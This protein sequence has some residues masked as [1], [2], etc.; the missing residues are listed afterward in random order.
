[1]K[2]ISEHIEQTQVIENID[3]ASASQWLLRQRPYKQSHVVS[4]SNVNNT[5]EGYKIKSALSY[6]TFL[7]LLQSNN[8]ELGHL[9]LFWYVL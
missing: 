3:G 6:K 5:L 1:M 4:F 2:Y 8:R 7:T 9:Y